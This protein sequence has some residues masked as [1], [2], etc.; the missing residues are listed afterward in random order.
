VSNNLITLK[1]L[2]EIQ[3]QNTSVL[4]LTSLGSQVIS[5]SHSHSQFNFDPVRQPNGHVWHKDRSVRDKH[6]LVHFMKL[7]S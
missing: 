3:L 7:D 6:I 4:S 5:G 1:V 2:A